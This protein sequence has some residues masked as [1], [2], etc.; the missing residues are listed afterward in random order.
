M[1]AAIFLSTVLLGASASAALATDA[2]TCEGL[3]NTVFSGGYVTSAR[4]IPAAETLPEYCEVRA[5]A[6]PAISI[7]VRLPLA[8]WN[9]KYYQAGCGGF[10]GILGRA[11]AGAGWINAMRPGLERGYATATSDSGHHGLSVV[12][13]AWADNNPH[14]ER[15]WGYRSISE[16]H[17]VAQVM[18]EAFYGSGSEQEIFQGCSTGGR[19]AH[20]AAQRF[21]E[22]FDGIISGA[23]AMN[24]TDLV[25][26]K[27]SYLMQVNLDADGNPILGP[28]K[29]GLIG[30]AV[31]AQCDAVDGAEDGV[32]ADPRACEVDLSGLQCTGAAGDDCLTEAELDVLAKW[33]QGPVNA[34]GEQLYPGGI[35]EG[36]EP[37]WWLWLTG[38]ADGGGRLVSAFADNF[39]AYMAFDQDP[40]HGWTAADFDFETDPARMSRSAGFYNADSPDLSAFRAAGGKM[41]VWHG[42]ADAIVTPY[43]TV[44]WYEKAAEAA[45]GEETLAEN[46]ALFMVPGLDHCGILAGPSGLTQAGLDPMTPLEAWLADG[47]APTS[48]LSAN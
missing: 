3:R 19:M 40:G 1:R 33:R 13:A 31:M 41:I 44:D 23:P 12:D 18:L 11:D 24:Y 38:N 9:G 32:I 26:T 29:D 25:G 20:M 46:V 22:L 5:T 30:D 15:D 10:C 37:F 42:W 47:T 14:A 16:T 2:A 48:I 6:L 43:K 17:R 8:G 28:G 35:P 36:S 7:E 4:V 27:M 21:P 39:G 45:G 34:A